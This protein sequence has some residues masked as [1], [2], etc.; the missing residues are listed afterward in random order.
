MTCMKCGRDIPAEQVFCDSCLEVME[1]YPV[2]PDAAIHLPTG[3]DLPSSKK[4]TGRRRQLS[5]EEQVLLLRKRNRRLRTTVAILSVLLA[6]SIA[7]AVLLQLHP[8][9]SKALPMGR[10]Y[11]I[12][13]TPNN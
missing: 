13:P 8:D 3:K 2:K 12:D 7:G 11:T 1:K 5:P 10:N 6:V 4:Q 9:V